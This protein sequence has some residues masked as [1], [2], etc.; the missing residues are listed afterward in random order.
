MRRKNELDK[1]DQFFKS[2]NQ[3]LGRG[4]QYEAIELFKA[5]ASSGDRLP[6]FQQCLSECQSE[7]CGSNQTRLP[8]ILRLTLW[9]CESNCKYTCQRKITI[10]A[11]KNNQ[12]IHQYYGKWP[13]IRLMGI[14]EPASVLFSLLNGYAHFI[15]WKNIERNVHPLNPSRLWLKAYVIIGVWTWFWSS[16]FHC[17]D[18]VFTERMDY[19]SAGFSVLFMFSIP[20]M[21]LI[22]DSGRH[23]TKL[24]TIVLSICYFC[25][26]FYLQF[27]RFSYT[28]NMVANA[29][30]GLLANVSWITCAVQMSKTGTKDYYVPIILILCTD[31]AFGLE[32]FDFPPILDILDAHS[33]WHLATFPITILWL[34]SRRPIPE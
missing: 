7:N 32:A 4:F 6:I 26:V 2:N 19:Y 3:V 15:N 27:I 29:I 23:A 1:F 17:R 30:V 33:L 13:F 11:E 22:R 31:L 21:Y 28:Y 24:L 20:T 25:H 9:D 14:Q 34:Y 5:N 10:E 18:F 12:E 16:V 8:L